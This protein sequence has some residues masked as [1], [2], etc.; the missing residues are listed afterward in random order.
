MRIGRLAALLILC[1]SFAFGQNVNWTASGDTTK[2]FPPSKWYIG[3]NKGFVLPDGSII[4]SSTFS[5]KVSRTDANQLRFTNTEND[6]FGDT[7]NVK[8]T[9]SKTFNAPPFNPD[10]LGFDYYP[11]IGISEDAV[12]GLISKPEGGHGSGINYI[13]VDSTTGDFINGWVNVRKTTDFKANLEWLYG[14]STNYWED[15]TTLMIL[16]TLGRLALNTTADGQAMLYAKG[17]ANTL[18]LLTLHNVNQRG[19]FGVDSSG[20]TTIVSEGNTPLGIDLTLDRYSSNTNAYTIVGRKARGS[21]QAPSQTL[22]GDRLLFLGSRGYT[23]SG[24]F[25]LNNG[26]AI[27][28]NAGENI[29]TSANGQYITFETTPNGSTTRA[30]A[31]R[32]TGA[33]D[34]GVGLTSPTAKVHVKAR[35]SQANALTIERSASSTAVA[36]VDTTGYGILSFLAVGSVSSG[37]RAK[38]D[39]VTVSDSTRI[40][41]SNGKISAIPVYE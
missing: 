5:D 31:A 1:S 16:D 15:G 6:F 32:I 12:L 28:L 37:N 25:N 22:S 35:N 38:I 29:T 41:F 26:A 36:T 23:N 7:V 19:R 18:R 24:S 20:L 14:R 13:E 40:Y 17:T 10:V 9:I 8:T 34:L 4:N 39:S 30:E 21:E 3:T 11:F 27:S 33:G 2:A